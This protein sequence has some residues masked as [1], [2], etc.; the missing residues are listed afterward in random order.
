MDIKSTPHACFCSRG[1]EIDLY[2]YVPRT[3]VET[4]S[5]YYMATEILILCSIS[6]LIQYSNGKHSLWRKPAFLCFDN[7]LLCIYRILRSCRGEFSQLNNFL[8]TYKEID[9]FLF[10]KYNTRIV[11]YIYTVYNKIR[12]SAD[13]NK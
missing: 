12:H 5:I 3:S 9:Y 6:K 10:Q 13:N 2:M 8:N 7:I 11:V 1:K 4:L